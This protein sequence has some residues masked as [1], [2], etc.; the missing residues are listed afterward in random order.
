MARR[1]TL[2]PTKITTYLACPVK[3]YWT[4]M[5]PK[6]KWYL[7]S[8]SYYSFGSSLH[9]VLQRFHDSR[10][11]GVTTTD[12]AIAALEESWIEAGYSS[13]DEM[14]QHLAEGKQIVE[15]HVER[16]LREPITAQTIVVEK[17]FRREL[18]PFVLLGRVDRIDEHEDGTI[19][20][21]DYK[22]GR[23]TVTEE[24]VRNDLAMTCYQLILAEHFP[25]R[26]ITASIIAVRSGHKATAQVVGPEMDEFR[27]M[28]VTLGEEILN[29]DWDGIEP[30]Y[31]ERL[32]MHCDFRSLCEQHPE[33]AVPYGG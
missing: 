10:D 30:T 15:A 27:S 11:A 22:S 19:E 21:I 18:G 4:Y 9:S 12:E 7:R 5:N 24:E 14:M 6:G 17:L 2:S 33:F 3:Y 20:I 8:K 25:D 29:R 31:K 32:C 16:S 1:P 13:Q 26:P 28:I 23:D